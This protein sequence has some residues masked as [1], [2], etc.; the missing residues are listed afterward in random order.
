MVCLKCRQCGA[1]L[2]WDGSADIV[3]C[4]Y[5][6][7][8]YCMHPREELFRQ[9]SVDPYKGRG[10]VQGIPVAPGLDFSGMVPVESYA[11][12][13]WTVQA[14]QASTDFYGD[15]SN[16][17][18]VVQTEYISPDGTARIIYRAENV[19]TDRKLSRLP[20]IRQIDVMGSFMRVGTPFSAEQYCDYLVRRDIQPVSVRKIRVEPA[21]EAELEK[22]KTIREQY[23]AHG[24]RQI[25]SE[26]RRVLYAAADPERKQKVVSVETRINDV[27]RPSQQPVTGVF[28]GQFMG[29][30][31]MDEH[32]WET[33]Y[34]L[35][36]IADRERYNETI[37]TAR[38]ILRTVRELPDL[39]KIKDTLIRYIRSLND[40]TAMAMHQ[41]ETASWE[42]KSQTVNDAHRYTMNVMHEMNANTAAAH[43]R[44]ANLRSES[45]RGVNTFHTA[46]PGYGTP[47]VVEADVR[48][49]HVYQSSR[50]ADIFAAAEQ[51]WLEPG[52]DFEELNRTDGNY[53]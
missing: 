17:P 1:A 36:L 40:R 35:I 11:P 45:I 8:E 51:V 19:Y 24:F 22:Q 10:T 31:A 49:D 33:Q 2:R 14:S 39:Q 29:G 20:L 21:D 43:D 50:D 26:W 30:G 3:R 41:Q 44:A 46:H 37:P 48:W 4:E 28:P 15:Y 9:R 7:A 5:C 27:H 42:R 13:G 25:T 12:E 34:E 6:G 23:T 47:D 18:Y 32:Y 16:N 53:R 52:L 38:G